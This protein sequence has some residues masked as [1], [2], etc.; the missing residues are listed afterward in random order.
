LFVFRSNQ[1]VLPLLRRAM[2]PI[3]AIIVF[4]QFC[5]TSLWFAG[6]AV[7]GDMLPVFG[8]GPQYLGYLTG[9]V[10]AGFISGTLFF[11]LMGIADR[12]SPSKVF[13]ICSLLGALCNVLITVDGMNATGLLAGRLLTGF[14]L[15]G[16][17]PVGMKIAA[18]YFRE[19]LGR[20][21]GFLVGALVLGTALPHLLKSFSLSLP[22][23]FVLYGTTLLSVAGGLLMLWLVPAGPHRR[24]GNRLSFANIW[25]PFRNLPFRAASFGY[26]G[27]MWELY[28]FWAFVP[29]MLSAYAALHPGTDFN[30]PLLSFWVIS[31]GAPAC[32]AG[33]ILSQKHGAEKVARVALTGSGICCLLSPVLFMQGYTELFIL[34]LLV[35]G[36]LVIADSPMFSSLV[37]QC[38]PAE[39]RGTALTLVTCIGFAITIASILLLNKMSAYITPVWLYWLLLPGPALGLWSMYANKK[40]SLT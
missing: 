36:I 18:D 27:H 40:R 8:L 24:A 4:A 29:A 3:L 35:W 39:G 5:C 37:A 21:L 23:K 6:N 16:I 26:F 38:A 28:T 31:I 19:G 22:W 10:Q 32:V 15:A 7:A 14:F 30:I 9:A 20:S 13:F 12:F 25:K 17:Y 11:A 2:R 34:F 1:P 33:G